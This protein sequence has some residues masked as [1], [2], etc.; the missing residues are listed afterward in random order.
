LLFAGPQVAYYIPKRI[1][2][3]RAE[4]VRRFLHLHLGPRA[5][6]VEPASAR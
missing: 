2:A 5:T 1:A 6:G 3:N 4:E